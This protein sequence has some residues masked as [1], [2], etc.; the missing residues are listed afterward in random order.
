MAVRAA[1][2][3]ERN[4][5]GARPAGADLCARHGA[6]RTRTARYSMD[7][8]DGYAAS[9]QRLYARLPRDEGAQPDRAVGRRARALRRGP[10]DGLRESAVGDGRRR[11]H[12]H[13]DHVRRR[14]DRRRRDVGADPR[15][16]TRTSSTTAR[17]AATSRARRRRR[18]MR[19]DFKVLERVTMP[20][21]PER[22]G[23]SLVVEAGRPGASPA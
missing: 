19:A 11:V 17:G 10:E 12:E 23:G 4:V 18:T 6:R 14:R 22:I 20:D 3:G 21:S 1:R 2:H 16:T 8:W 9:R 15:R 5:D 13:V 7:K